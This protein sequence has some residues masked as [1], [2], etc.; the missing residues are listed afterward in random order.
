LRDRDVIDLGCGFGAL[1]LVFAVRG[2]RVTALD[3]NAPRLNVGAQVADLHGLAVGWKVGGME[4]TDLG[5]MRYDIAFMNN[6]FCYLVAAAKRERAL[7]R[8]L[9]ALRPGG[10]L[11]VRDPSRLRLR[12]QFTG[13]PLLGML[14]PPLARTVS[15]VLGR[16]RSDVRLRSKAVARRELR[17]A[18]FVDV[19]TVAPPG[20][21]RL[22]ASFAAYH[23]LVARRPGAS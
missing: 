8:A 5:H 3:P 9:E 15:R 2:A 19:Q 6:S 23:H 18:G 20:R 13:L 16:S 1:A 4:A 21:S 10:V 14:P 11:V 22:A 7:A 17:E 12:D